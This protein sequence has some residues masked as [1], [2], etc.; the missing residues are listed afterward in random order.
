MS[1]FLKRFA[2]FLLVLIVVLVLAWVI[3][4]SMFERQVGQ[5]LVST[6]N[7][8]LKTEL[9]VREFDLSAI[10]TLPNV[11]ANLKG[12][13]LKDN[14]GGVLLEAEELSFRFGLLSLFGSSLNVKSVVVSDGALNIQMDKQG[15]GNYDIFKETEPRERKADDNA[16]TNIDLETAQLRNMEVIYEDEGASQTLLM[17]V[18]NASFTGQFSNQKFALKSQADIVSNFIEM[19]STRY[20]VGQNIGYEA[21]ILVNLEQGVYDLQKVNIKLGENVFNVDGTY[22]TWEEGPY[23]DLF[24]T[25]TKGNLSSLIALLPEQYLALLGDFTSQGDF[26]FKA[27]IKGQSKQGLDPEIRAEVNLQ[28]GRI[29][30]PRMKEPLR[31]VSFRATFT[32]GK[33]RTDDSAIFEIENLK[34]YFNRELFEMRLKVENL[35]DPRID[36]LANGAVPMESL[37]GL[38]N[39]P[40]ITGGSGEIEVKNLLL[41]GRYKD[42]ISTSTISRVRAGGEIEFDD[43]ALT[44]NEEKMVIDRGQ[45]L[46][47]GDTLSVPEFELNGAG[48][49]ILFKGQAISVIPFLFADSL[50]TNRVELQYQAD[51]QS[52]NLDIDRLMKLSALTED[53]QKADTL[54]VD[55]LK[56]DNIQKRQQFTQFLKGIFNARIQNF[57]YNEI[58]GSDFIGKLEFN[59]NELIINGDT[60]AMQ[61]TFDLD[62]KVYFEKAP[63]LTAKLTC[64][65]I[66]ATEFFR[67]TENF[68]QD[69]LTNKN[70]SGALNA[71]IAIYAYWDT[72]GT[73]QYDKLRVIAGLDIQNGQLKDFKMM[74]QFSTYVKMRD[75]MDIRFANLENYIEIADQKLYLPVMFIQ[76]NAM[77]LTVSGEHSFENIMDYNIKVNAGQ[78]MANRFKASSSQPQ[79]AK[80]KGWFNLYFNIAG[81]VDEYKVQTA[82]K[83]VQKNFLFSER[84]KE[85]VQQALEREFGSVRKIEEP[86]ETRDVEYLDEV[87]GGQGN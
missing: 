72:T 4:A 40:K 5:Q 1:K 80:K 33:F 41:N 18:K 14:H 79:P 19:D 22:E 55:S 45:L 65:K 63:R 3:I 44:I 11:A 24:F 43:A 85:R 52:Q 74:E 50:N 26:E 49:D 47:N 38:F 2:I 73:F 23:F 78:V 67:Q 8:Q 77:N 16:G 83:E 53:E 34:G 87:E 62:G 86:A 17:D 27:A 68:G 39:N 54:T 48:S 30:S 37:Y 29:E 6:I 56:S 81:T 10:R 42:M 84:R 61:G 28:N 35:D 76:S 57:N 12:V 32:N 70:V 9:T 71:Q 58:K 46:L 20:L 82:K 25:C 64:E 75:L 21:D 36:F 15:K 51:L 60:K 69:I 13:V 66:D 31:D 59:N 7:K